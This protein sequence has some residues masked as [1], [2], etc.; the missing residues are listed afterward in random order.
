MNSS[1]PTII[2]TYSAKFTV[3][4]ARQHSFY[5]FYTFSSEHKDEAICHCFDPYCAPRSA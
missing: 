5:D 1:S 3:K 4:C 2:R